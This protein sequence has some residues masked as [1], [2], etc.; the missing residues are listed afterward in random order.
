MEKL[1]LISLLISFLATI[2]AMP[3]W[4]KRA[5]HAG[6]VGKDINKSSLKEVA[7]AGGIIVIFGFVLGVLS[8]V[9]LKTF[10]FKSSDNLTEIFALLCTI[11]LISF[12]G[13]ID[14][15]LGWKIGLGKR[16]RIVLLIFAA[17]PLMVINAGSPGVFIPFI[18]SVNLGL[19][20]ALIIIPIGIVGASSTFNFLA[21]YNGLEASQGILLL[22]AVSAMSIITGSSWLGLIGLCMVFSLIAFLYY[23]KFPAKIFPGDVM[24]YSI[25]GLIAIMAILGNY[26]FFAVFIFIPY[27][28]ETVLKSRGRLKKES[29]G[30]PQKDGSIK[31]KYDKIYGL[32]HLAI[33]ILEKIKPSKKAY[34]WEVVLLINFFQLIVIA[35][36]FLL[37]V[38]WEV[39]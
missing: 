18:G 3:F 7:E 14:D 8:Y 24:T 32:E 33:R 16:V 30:E 1:L 17:I 23:N 19:I 6:L 22:L 36:G 35:L 31:N 5:K 9:A 26:E 12:I 34:E 4:I 27:I 10:Y 2:I 20:Y 37:F 11:I 29:F 39:I 13:I 21:G 15:I 28:L 38:V 25:G